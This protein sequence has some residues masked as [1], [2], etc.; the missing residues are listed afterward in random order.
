MYAYCG[1]NPVSRVD[2]KGE[3]WNVIIGAAIGFATSLVS[4]AIDVGA[5]ILTKN[6]VGKSITLSFC[7][8]RLL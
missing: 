3:C 7:S 1:N 5:K 6:P 4:N 8:K 2:D